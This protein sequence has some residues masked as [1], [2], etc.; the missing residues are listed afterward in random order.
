M[1]LASCKIKNTT[2]PVVVDDHKEIDL[3][4]GCAY[5]DAHELRLGE[6]V[7]AF[8][9]G[10]VEIDA[11]GE[12][13]DESNGQYL[14]LV[15]YADELTEDQLMKPGTYT[16]SS[17]A[18]AWSACMG[19]DV[20]PTHP[21]YAYGGSLIYN[22]EDGFRTEAVKIVAGSVTLEGSEDDARFVI[23]VLGS[24][25]IEYKYKSSGPVNMLDSLPEADAF[26]KGYEKDS[27][28]EITINADK[29]VMTIYMN[30][31]AFVLYLSN[32]NGGYSAKIG[33]TFQS[34]GKK[35]VGT[36]PVGKD[37]YDRSPGVTYYSKG[38]R[39]GNLYTSF[40]G[41]SNDGGRTY[42]CDNHSIFFITGGSMTIDENDNVTATFTTFY[43]STVNVNFTGKL[44]RR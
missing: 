33:A 34:S 32:S 7:F 38:C 41:V 42:D 2:D 6:Q 9:I 31:N 10:D 12:V 5:G 20:D 19:Y 4:Y 15:L 14:Q 40:A 25:G 30:E 35:T 37:A 39:N 22:V 8:A 13:T 43:G 11:K 29:G 16:I 27:I 21:G 23:D 18:E 24:D 26:Y 3:Q 36:F 28:Q 17:E 44:T 1:L